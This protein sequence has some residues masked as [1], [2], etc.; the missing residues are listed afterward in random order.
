MSHQQSDV[1]GLLRTHFHSVD[2]MIENLSALLPT[3][4]PIKDF[5]HHN[6]LHSF[7]HLEFGEAL[8]QASYIFGTDLSYLLTDS[9]KTQ[10]FRSGPL[11]NK[12]KFDG[13][14]NNG[15]RRQRAL[16]HNYDVDIDALPMIIRLTAAYYD[17]GLGIWPHPVENFGS[18]GLWRAT[19]ELVKSST[20]PLIPLNRGTC[21]DLLDAPP[22]K[23]IETCLDLLTTN[24]LRSR[25]V[26]EVF[27]T[28]PG[29]A[30]FIMSC[31]EA[32]ELL[33]QH[34]HAS[35][36]DWL[37]LFLAVEVGFIESKCPSAMFQKSLDTQS[38][39]LKSA[40]HQDDQKRIGNII[41]R[42]LEKGEWSAYSAILKHTKTKASDHLRDLIK[43]PPKMQVITC[44]DD[45]EFS[46]RGLLESED[47]DIATYGAPG[48]FGIDCMI[49]D[50]ASG[51]LVKHCPV[52]VNP[53]HILRV[54]HARKHGK[55]TV[56][57]SKAP[58]LMRGW[59]FTQLFGIPTGLKLLAGTMAPKLVENRRLD[60]RGKRLTIDVLVDNPQSDSEGRQFGYTIPEAAARVSGLLNTIGLNKSFAPLIFVI[61]HGASS[62]NNPYFAAYDCGACSGRPGALNA[63]AFCIMA[64]D[65]NV[66]I[67]LRN[68]GIDISNQTT[69]I[70]MIHDTTADRIDVV[71]ELSLGVD[72]Q[73]IFQ[74]FTRSA[75]KAL[76]KNSLYRCRQFDLADK[77]LSSHA[78]HSHVELR[79]VAWFEPRPEYNHATNIACVVGRRELTASMKSD[80]AIFLQSYNPSDDTEGKYLVGI[81]GAVIPVCGGINLEYFFSRVDSEIYGAGSKLPQNVSG[82]NGVMT[83]LESDLRTGLP[84]QM[85]EIH[86]AMRLLI[87]VE[88]KPEVILIALDK[89]PHLKDWVNNRWVWLVSQDPETGEQC[90][91]RD[92]QFENLEPKHA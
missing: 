37:A 92:R 20:L 18:L 84:A 76:E 34:R 12:K 82:L 25:Y 54:V 42:K 13:I 5:I 90:V 74:Q 15:I 91:Y 2:T 16:S 28:L 32:P 68:L 21:R 43:P 71:G 23:A 50:G 70:P 55:K 58:A 51:D 48:F 49:Q 53:K 7:Q 27:L 3:Q 52:P 60:Y 88:Q 80:R 67:K 61:G 6:T 11:K 17:Q 62:V 9:G 39:E 4:G 10:E 22:H 46:F 89:L 65:K 35:L 56:I 87:L 30:G 40:L 24:A 79:S 78:A 85:T 72:Q 1:I 29:W 69:F 36:A 8:A 45:R 31:H 38:S 14:A 41:E 33:V 86:D 59:L 57:E 83:G 44:I 73:G 19:N 66:R 64:N 81:L 26:A 63:L 77:N 75:H 47:K